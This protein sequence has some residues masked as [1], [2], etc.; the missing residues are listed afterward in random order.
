MSD[1]AAALG[2]IPSG[3]FILTAKLGEESSGMLASWVMQAG[4]EPPTLTVAVNRE[5]YLADWLQKGA[6]VVV[7]I[8]AEDEKDMISHFGRGIKPGEPAF[9]GVDLL[10][11]EA[12]APVLADALAFLAG[13]VAASLDAGDHLLFLVHIKSGRMLREGAPMLH[14]R[15]NGLRY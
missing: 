15:K 11:G 6:H 14:V 5:R 7:N 13:D 8:L 3:I 9:N 10:E 2:R 4:F 12:S 1:L